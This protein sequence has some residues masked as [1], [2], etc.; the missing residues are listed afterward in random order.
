MAGSAA[1]VIR[2]CI[3]QGRRLAL[4]EAAPFVTVDSALSI[5]PPGA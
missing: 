4:T 5:N 1:S 2:G 3:G